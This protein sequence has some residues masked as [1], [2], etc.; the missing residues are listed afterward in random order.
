MKRILIAAALLISAL[1]GAQDFKAQY[2]RQIRMVGYSGVGV[3]TILNRWEEAE[4]DNT[5]MLEGRF[6]YYFAKSKSSSVVAKNQAKFLGAEPVITLK[7]STGRDVGYFEEDFFVD[8]LFALSQKAVDRAIALEPSE[9]AWRVD[10]INALILYEKESPELAGAEI[11]KMADYQASKHPEWTHYGKPVTEDTFIQAVQEYCFTFFR[12]GTPGSYEE[13]RKVSEKMNKL[14]P[15]NTDFINNLG[16]YY[17]V[18]QDSPKKALKWYGKS[19][20]INPSDY[21]AARNCVLVARRDKNVKMEK[22]YLPAL[23]AATTDE[24]ERMGYEAR[25]KALE[26][27]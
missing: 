19:L 18:C 4:P 27:K 20:K 22:K 12:Y 24:I 5:A 14:Y 9:L 21:S 23:I 2:D 13:F 8:S 1:C 6:H 17:L 16:S 10:K 15:K 3:E 25:L 11:I 26:K 7:D